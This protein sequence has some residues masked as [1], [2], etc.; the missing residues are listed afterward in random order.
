M[1]LSVFVQGIT[2]ALLAQRYG[3]ASDLTG[4]PQDG[5]AVDEL[6]IRG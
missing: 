3:G 4:A 2:S 1:L 5:P 6:A